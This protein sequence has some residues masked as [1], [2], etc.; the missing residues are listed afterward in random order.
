MAGQFRKPE[1]IAVIIIAFFIK[2][3]Q[4]DMYSAIHFTSTYSL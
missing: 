1:V 4:C 2:F 3:P